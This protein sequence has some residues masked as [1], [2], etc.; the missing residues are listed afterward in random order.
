MSPDTLEFLPS[1]IAAGKIKTVSTKDTLTS[2]TTSLLGNLELD[3]KILFITLG[4][5]KAVQ[6]ALADTLATVTQP[7]DD[8]LYNTLLALGIRVGEADVRVTGVTCQ[9]PVLVQ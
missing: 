9:R 8:V 6:Q 1:D 7:L 5:P 4:T 3:I 2:L